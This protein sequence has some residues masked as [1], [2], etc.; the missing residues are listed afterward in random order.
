MNKSVERTEELFNDM[1]YLYNKDETA[2]AEKELTALL[3]VN[4]LNANTY[5]KYT[6][7]ALEITTHHYRSIISKPIQSDGEHDFITSMRMKAINHLLKW[8]KTYKMEFESF[9]MSM[10]KN[11]FDDVDDMVIFVL[12]YDFMNN[13]H[14]K[15]IHI[16][17]EVEVLG[18][19]YKPYDFNISMVELKNLLNEDIEDGA[20]IQILSNKDMEE[21]IMNHKYIRGE[22]K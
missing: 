15:L 13:Q 22:E 21:E 11:N 16:D 8:I 2:H 6:L 18:K 4:A 17:T 3:R 20:E 10:S 1:S 9:L 7:S 12:W 5:L 19:K 14:F